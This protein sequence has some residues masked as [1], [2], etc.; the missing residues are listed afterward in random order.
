LQAIQKV[1]EI[2]V[3]NVIT[4]KPETNLT[5]I[6]RLMRKNRIGSIVIIKNGSPVGI[7]TESDSSSS[8]HEEPI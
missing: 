2:M 1:K 8:W 4:A 5:D 3:R 7:L 6:A